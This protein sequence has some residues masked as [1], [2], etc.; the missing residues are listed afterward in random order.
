[1]DLLVDARDPRRRCRFR[2]ACFVVHV[3]AK[4]DG[5]V[6]VE[7][8]VLILL[9]GLTIAG[10]RWGHNSRVTGRQLP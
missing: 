1:M 7:I 6:A 9:I 4:R 5:G 10:G 8:L 3:K 2:A